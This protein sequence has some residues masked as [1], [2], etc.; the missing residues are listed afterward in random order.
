MTRNIDKNLVLYIDGSRFNGHIGAL[1]YLP[2]LGTIQRSHL[3]LDMSS[4]VYT[5]E[6]VGINMALNLCRQLRDHTGERLHERFIQAT[7]FTDSQA[8]IKSIMRPGRASGMQVLGEI[9]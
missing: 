7:I 8:T 5:G 2:Q 4:T 9:L 1:A 6:L 3:G